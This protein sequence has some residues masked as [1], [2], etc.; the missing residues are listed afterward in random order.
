M[1]DCERINSRSQ[2]IYHDTSSLWQP[3]QSPNR[4]RLPHIEG[5]KEYKAR[6][7]GFPCEGNGNQR[8]QLPRDL[9][10]DNELRVFGAMSACDPGGSGDSNDGYGCGGYERRPGTAR[11]RDAGAG[12]RPQQQRRQ[13]TPRSGTGLQA[14][15][16]EECR[17]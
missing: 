8:N 1:H 16:A 7:K 9:V 12:Q 14:A 4:K 5:T 11:W 6:E 2:V 3:L 10:D 15:H 17:D 13:R